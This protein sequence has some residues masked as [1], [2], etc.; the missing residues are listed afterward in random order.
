MG[1]RMKGRIASSIMCADLAHLEQTL[2]RH[3]EAGIEAIHVDIMDGNFVPNYT[4]G[5]DFC[6][7]L[8]SLTRIP[9]DIHLMVQNPER[10]P[11]LWELRQGDWVCLHQE[12]TP[13]LQKALSLFR[14]RGAETGVALNP[15]T[16]LHTIEEVL[17]D[18]RFVLVMTVNPGYAGQSLIPGTL[19]KIRRARELLD[20]RGHRQVQIEVDGNVSFEN[21][22]L[23]RR[24]GADI[25]VAGTS[26][27]FAKGLDFAEAV[28]RLRKSIQ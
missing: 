5:P 18:I 28:A 10:Y 2:R 8:R 4:F 24:M 6:R 11:D 3:E 15:G 13:H 19:E 27:I 22:A 23:M 16:S 21:A 17:E 1:T 12:S 20:S 14:A 7:V 26:S 9:L 25:F